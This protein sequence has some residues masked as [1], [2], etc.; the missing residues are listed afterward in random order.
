[1]WIRSNEHLNAS[2]VLG[3]T[4]RTLTNII[5]LSSH[6]SA[7]KKLLS[8]F[9]TW[10]WA[11]CPRL[12]ILLY[13]RAVGFSACHSL[14]LDLLPV[15]TH[16]A[17]HASVVL[18]M[19]FQQEHLLLLWLPRHLFSKWSSGDHL[20]SLPWPPLSYLLMSLALSVFL[21]CFMYSSNC[22]SKKYNSSYSVC[23]SNWLWPPVRAQTLQKIHF[24]PGNSPVPGS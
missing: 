18:K 16:F 6:W 11:N 20:R 7:M 13:D 8:A 12:P 2:H 5:R 9:H 23:L 15:L 24:A 14:T 22:D 17:F 19:M 4:L 1:M 10:G 21:R 3:A